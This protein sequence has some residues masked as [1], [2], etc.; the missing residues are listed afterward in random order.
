MLAKPQEGNPVW[1][2][3]SFVQ[4]WGFLVRLV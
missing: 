1:V 3:F 4:L 2:P